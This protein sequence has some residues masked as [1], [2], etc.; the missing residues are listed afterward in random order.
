MFASPPFAEDWPE[1]HALDFL[2]QWHSLFGLS[3]AVPSAIFSLK[4]P[5]DVV[6]LKNLI[7]KP[8]K[9]HGA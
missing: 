6:P 3:F 5:A 8:Q 1:Y 2:R 9:D 4:E 7:L